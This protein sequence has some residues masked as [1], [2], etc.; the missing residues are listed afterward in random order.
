MENFNK[1]ID[2]LNQYF[3]NLDNY[4]TNNLFLT[5]YESRNVFNYKLKRTPHYFDFK[6]RVDSQ[7]NI[8]TKTKKIGFS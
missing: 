2:S 5:D 1:K 8:I 4:K 7:F 3:Y 6:C